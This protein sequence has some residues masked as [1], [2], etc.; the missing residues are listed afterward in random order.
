MNDGTFLIY[1]KVMRDGKQVC[2]TED[3]VTARSAD[4]AMAQIAAR[5]DHVPT[6][7]ITVRHPE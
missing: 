6:H 7:Y 4:A 3:R 1:S 5:G 2:L